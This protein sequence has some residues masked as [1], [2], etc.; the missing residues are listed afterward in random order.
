MGTGDSIAGALYHPPRSQYTTESILAYI[1]ASVEELLIAYPTTLI[2]LAGDFN[3]LTDCEVTMTTGLHQTVR[4]PTRGPNVLD[5]IFVSEPASNTVRVVTST[6]RS[7]H[8]AVVA[9]TGECRAASKTKTVKT[10]R[11]VTPARHASFL[12]YAEQSDIFDTNA[13]C[14]DIQIATDTFYVIA[15]QLLD[16]FYPQ[17]TIT[18]SSRDPSYVTPVIKAKQR[19]KNRLMRAGR[20]EEASAIAQSIGRAI[21]QRS[22]LQLSRINRK[23]SSKDMWTAVKQITGRQQDIPTADGFTAEA[24]NRHYAGISSDQNYW[25]PQKRHTVALSH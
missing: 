5:R 7:D 22:K 24:L 14:T 17:R 19:R 21:A 12:R 3:Q 8:K 15:L 18:V 4:Q 2:I 23:T 1:E 25:P 13:A 11:P 10:F 20:V 16:H 6:V 9:Y